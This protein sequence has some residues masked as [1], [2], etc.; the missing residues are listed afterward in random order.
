MRVERERG[1]WQAAQVSSRRRK[2]RIKYRQV[3]WRDGGERCGCRMGSGW[4]MN[5]ERERESG[6][7]CFFTIIT[8][9]YFVTSYYLSPLSLSLYT[10]NQLSITPITAR[11]YSIITELC[12]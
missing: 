10:V 9:F 8:L 12:V 4:D 7:F 6:G 2:G 1:G 3:G 11:A 5:G